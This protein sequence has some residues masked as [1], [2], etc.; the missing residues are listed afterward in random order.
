MDMDKAAEE[1][2]AS[3]DVVHLTITLFVLGFGV[4]AL[5]F[6]PLSEMFGRRWP[7]IISMGLY[8]IFTFPSA[9]ARNV[10]T[11]VVGRALAGLSASAPMCI[12][13]GSLADLWSEE[14]RGR[15]LAVFSMTVFVGPIVGPVSPDRFCVK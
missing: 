4:G 2:G 13:G 11:L 8:F 1:F 10:T 14:Q 15:P 5:L 7:V 12:I 6:A 3:I 9:F